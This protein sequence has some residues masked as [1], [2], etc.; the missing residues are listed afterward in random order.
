MLRVT[1]GDTRDYRPIVEHPYTE[2][3]IRIARADLLAWCESRGIRPPMLFPDPPI[4][5]NAP[6]NDDLSG[7]RTPALDALRAAIR[8]FWLHHD[9]KR[10]PKG[11]DIVGWLK[12]ECGMTK[13]MA[14][15]IDR[16]I[17]PAIYAKGGNIKRS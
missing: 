15:S 9:P 16:V 7:H 3:I 4:A 12:D 14:E 2:T 8:Q 17:R 13:T 11:P 5:A 10:P 6:D 1:I